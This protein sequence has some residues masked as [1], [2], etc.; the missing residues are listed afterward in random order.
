[1]SA[2]L[3]CELDRLGGGGGRTDLSYLCVEVDL[4]LDCFREAD[5]HFVKV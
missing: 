1:M 3:L 2:F 4:P 5:K